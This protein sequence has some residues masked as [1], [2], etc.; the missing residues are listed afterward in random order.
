[1][2]KLPDYQRYVAIKTV[3]SFRK[4]KPRT[5]EEYCEELQKTMMLAY[6][7]PAEVFSTNKSTSEDTAKTKK[8]LELF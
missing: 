1:M 2:Q 3:N 6:G 7:L 5:R 4:Y 8:I